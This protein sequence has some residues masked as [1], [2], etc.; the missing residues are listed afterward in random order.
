MNRYQETFKRLSCLKEGCFIPFVVLGD[1]SLET[2]I[3]IIET[4]IKSGADALEIGIPFS[5]PLADGP[6]V[7]KSNLRALSKN[8]TFFEYFKILKQLRKKN[9]KLPIGILIYA[10]L[11]YNQGIDNFYFQCFNS[12][13]DSVLIA[14]VPIEESKIFYNIANKYK[15]NPIFICPPDADADFLYKI[16]LYAQGFIYVLSRPGVT[17][18]KNNTIALPRDFIN[19]IKKYNSVPLLQGFGISNP[20]QIKE[21][22]SSGLSGVICGSAIINIIEKYL[23]QEKKM[24]KEIKKFTHLLKLST[25][26]E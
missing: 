4:L 7:Q 19:K 9:K 22:I 3:K 10:N 1:P 6:T 21:A 8:N 17:G 25:K 16:S 15:I 12:G 20:K 24:I 14:D 2:S 11:V 13:L 18:I 23:N 5:D 26:L